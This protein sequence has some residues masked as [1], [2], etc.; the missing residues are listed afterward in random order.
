MQLAQAHINSVSKMMRPSTRELPRVHKI[1]LNSSDMVSGGTLAN[2]SFNNVRLP[3]TFKRQAVVMVSSWQAVNSDEG[4]NALQ[5][6]NVHVDGWHHIN[7]YSSKTGSLSDVLFTTTG[8]S[9]SQECTL[10]DIGGTVI[11][12]P[13]QLVNKTLR[14]I[15]ESPLN[16]SFS[17][18]NPWI[19]TLLIYER[20][21]SDVLP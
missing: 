12:D 15:V 6:Y 9:F 14:V 3:E 4:A 16:T 7:S 5:V 17:W 18:T 20:S 8:Y 10:N 13:T 2:A 21:D 19:L 1:I 11:L